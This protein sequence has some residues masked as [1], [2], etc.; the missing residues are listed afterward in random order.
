MGD[1]CLE[2]LSRSY[3]E[4]EYL[5]KLVLILNRNDLSPSALCDVVQKLDG[6]GMMNH[7]YIQAKKNIRK[8]SEKDSVRETIAKLM[9]K[10]KKIDL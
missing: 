10:K 4:Y 1:E 7:V 8:I 6:L 2:I 9:I 5:E 3:T